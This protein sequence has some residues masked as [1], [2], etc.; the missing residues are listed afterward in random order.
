VTLARE[1]LLKLAPALVL[2]LVLVGGGAGLIWYAENSLKAARESLAAAR[3]NRTQ[4]REKLS[5]IAEEERDVKEKLEVYRQ[6]K[7]VRVLGEERRLEWADTVAR[8]RKERELLDVRYRV[9]P[10]RMMVSLPG[11][12]A[13]VEFYNSLMKVN[14]ALLH[15][16]DLFAFLDDLRGS[17][18]AY[19]SVQRCIVTRTGQLASTANL[20]P[21]LNAECEIELITIMDRGAKP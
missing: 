5:K 15:E 14:L 3:E 8:I 9:E 16:G 17:G 6:L 11:K 10:Q 7:E 20:A 21:R 4:N 19:Y 13:P 12:P 1:E 2:L 18:N